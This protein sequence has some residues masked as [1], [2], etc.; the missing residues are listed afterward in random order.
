[1]RCSA[2]SLRSPW[3][4]WHN[5]RRLP[6][7]SSFSPDRSQPSSP[8]PRLQQMAVGPVTEVLGAAPAH[9]AHMGGEALRP[10]P[11][12][13]AVSVSDLRELARRRLPRVMFGLLEG[14]SEDERALAMNYRR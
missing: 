13:E 8:A 6:I 7:S 2:T 10:G 14:A 9:P 3:V 12:A 11:E 5:P 1:M 4:A